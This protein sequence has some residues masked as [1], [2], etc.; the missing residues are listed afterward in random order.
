MK[1]SHIDVEIVAALPFLEVPF[2]ALPLGLALLIDI[3]AQL[4]LIC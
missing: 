3:L 2:Y 1:C 4:I